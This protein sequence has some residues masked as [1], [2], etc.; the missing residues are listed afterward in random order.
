MKVAAT[1]RRTP[2]LRCAAIAVAAICFQ[3]G[4]FQTGAIAAETEAVA[5]VDS[6]STNRAGFRISLDAAGAAEMT[7]VPRGRA[8]VSENALP[9]R[10]AIP[11]ALAERLR[12]DL[13]EARPLAGLPAARCMK[14]ASFGSS[15]SVEAGNERT[16]DLNC[17]DGGNAEL[18][19]LIRDVREIVALFRDN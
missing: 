3:S 10:R 15:L 7:L 5:I 11:Q 13:A 8:A 9:V 4:A 1:N 6:G 18:R 16:P 14:S 19:K 17:G 2:L 12:A